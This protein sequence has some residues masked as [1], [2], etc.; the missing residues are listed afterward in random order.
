MLSKLL[1]RP[2]VPKAVGVHP[3]V[4]PVDFVYRCFVGNQYCCPRTFYSK[5]RVSE[6]Q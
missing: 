3:L 4:L 5:V 2:D 6:G 1:S